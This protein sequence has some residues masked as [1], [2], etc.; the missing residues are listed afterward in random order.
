MRIGDPSTQHKGRNSYQASP[1]A[2]Q[3]AENVQNVLENE[4]IKI[5]RERS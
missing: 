1:L 2:Q 4:V 3:A 5:A